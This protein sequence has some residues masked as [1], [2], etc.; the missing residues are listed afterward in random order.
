V[1]ARYSTLIA[2]NMQVRDRQP[3]DLGNMDGWI[4]SAQ[5]NSSDCRA[6]IEQGKCLRWPSIVMQ[7]R[8]DQQVSDSL[9]HGVVT[10]RLSIKQISAGKIPNDNGIHG[11]VTRGCERI[12]KVWICMCVVGSD[13]A[14]VQRHLAMWLSLRI[15]ELYPAAIIVRGVAKDGAKVNFG[16][17]GLIEDTATNTSIVRIVARNSLGNI[18]RDGTI[19]DIKCTL[20]IINA[21][22]KTILLVV[23]LSGITRDGAVRYQQCAIII[24]AA[25]LAIAVLSPFRSLSG[26]ARDG[27]VRYQQCA[28][29]MDA[30][31]K[32]PTIANSLSNIVRDNTVVDNNSAVIII[33]DTTTVTIFTLRLTIP[34]GN[35]AKDD[36]IVEGKDTPI[37]G[38]ATTKLTS[39]T[40]DDAIAQRKIA[41]AIVDD[42]KTI[43]GVGTILEG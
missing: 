6:A 29:I 32:T 15:I 5:R 4:A 14:V 24:D 1:G 2:S 42:A 31:T 22:T 33:F 28:I 12:T 38:N 21:A 7:V 27:A 19:H 30:A 36:T 26:I 10:M 3:L 16:M 20:V 34:L 39:I 41:T 18:A 17:A 9:L 8:V 40:R 37:I 11:N 25:P 43:L 35:I 23:T 13:K